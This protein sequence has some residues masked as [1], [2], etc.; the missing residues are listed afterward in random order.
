MN[1]FRLK[2]KLMRTVVYYDPSAKIIIFQTAF[3]E[4]FQNCHLE[5]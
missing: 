5:F 4:C 1:M 3:D 2:D